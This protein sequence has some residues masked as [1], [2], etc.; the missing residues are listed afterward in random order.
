MRELTARQRAFIRAIVAMH[1]RENAVEAARRAGYRWPSKVG[2]ALRH[3]P[4]V[5]AELE[6]L[7]ARAW[8]DFDR[9][10]QAEIASEEAR[11]HAVLSEAGRRGRAAADSKIRAYNRRRRFR[12]NMGH[13]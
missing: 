4:A 12:R 2:W 11:R 6:P 3:H 9:R 10:M 5:R 13:E 1:P 7:L 8:Q